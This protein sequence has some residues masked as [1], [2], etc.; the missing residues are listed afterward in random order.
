MAQKTIIENTKKFPVQV[1]ESDR[2]TSGLLTEIL[3]ELRVLNM[4]FEEANET[5]FN[6]IDLEESDDG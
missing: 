4:K 1:H 5:G 3:Y 6:I 2:T